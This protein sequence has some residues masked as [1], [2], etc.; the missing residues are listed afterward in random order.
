M[1]R[2]SFFASLVFCM[3]TC[4]QCVGVSAVHEQHRASARIEHD[5]RALAS[6]GTRHTLSSSADSKRGIAAACAW[7]HSEFDVISRDFHAGRL[8]VELHREQLPPSKRVPEGGALTN[9]VALLPGSEPDRI[10][11]VSAH[12]D[13]RCSDPLDALSDAPGA[14]DDASGTALVLECARALAGMQ[15]RATIAFV[16]VAGEEQGL[17]GSKAL[18]ARWAA[19]GRQVEAFITCDIIGGARGSNGQRDAQRVRLFSEGVP[20]S[21]AKVVGSDNDAPS[22]QLARFIE[23]TA[24]HANAAFDVELVFRQDRFLRG[25]DHKSFNDVGVA[26]VRFTEPNENYAQQHHD[27]VV[28]GGVAFGD[29]P[30]FVDFDYVARVTDVCALS[31]RAL[32]LAPAPPA[33]VTMDARELSPDTALSWTPN[34]HVARYRVRARRTWQPTWTETIE[35]TARDQATLSGW[36]KDDWCFAVEALDEDGRASLPVVPAAR[37]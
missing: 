2:S 15:P 21:G 16:C 23:A 8:V 26:A 4:T 24:E 9:V 12:Y 1:E 11:A 27:V 20:S 22:R 36:S 33:G 28:E 18:A 30:E 3:A 6:F 25:G 19:E 32:A 13:S 37:Q 34:E 35:V 10:V 17:L 14:N 5:I 31:L 29:L 7:L